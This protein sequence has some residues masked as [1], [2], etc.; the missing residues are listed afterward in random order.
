MTL[1]R[2]LIGFLL[3]CMTAGLS[4]AG[5]AS[6]H[7]IR[8]ALL[9]IKETQQ[10]W[11][12]VTWKVPMRGTRQLAMT[13]KLP[14]SLK[15]FGPVS[16]RMVPGAAIEYSSYRSDGKTLVGQRIGIE[17][18]TALQI[19]VLLQV[20][21]ADGSQHS[22]ILRPK[23]PSY[24]I[25][26]RE[27]KWAVSWSYW[28][29][30]T[31][32][33][34]EGI[35]HLLFVLALMLIVVGYWKLFKTITAF[36]LAHSLTLGLATLGFVHFPSGPTE[37]VIAL[38]I[39][40]LAGEIIHSR[41]GK[42]GLTERYPWIVAFLFGLFHGLGF[43]GAL[44]EVGLP[45]HEV[46][47]ALCMFNVGVES[48]QILFLAGVLLILGFLRRLPVSWPRESWR[49]LPYTIGSLAA[50]WTIQRIESFL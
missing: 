45:Q 24:T 39:L 4:M 40:F 42:S 16:R 6:A 41:E 35:D 23:S 37:A 48:G 34:L 5:A 21:M 46:P 44:N 9:Q 28:R 50:F 13:P 49:L 10:G 17:G 3:A 8:P 11:F 2:R 26:E 38:S 18:L 14:E 20:S 33:I 15:S 22:A 43:A 19:D 7:E 25:P 30:G 47:L 36:T 31:I 29:M 1:K 32:H 27:S 12:E